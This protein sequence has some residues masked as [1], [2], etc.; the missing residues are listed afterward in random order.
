MDN[1]A[2][3]LLPNVAPEQNPS[4]TIIDIHKPG[5]RMNRVDTVLAH[6]SWTEAATLPDSTIDY[7]RE[8]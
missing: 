2:V 3:L 6:E 5:H 7:T 4:W 8:R 1:P